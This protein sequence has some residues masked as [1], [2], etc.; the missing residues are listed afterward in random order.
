MLYYV[1]GFQPEDIGIHQ[2]VYQSR[3]TIPETSTFQLLLKHTITL[4]RQFHA[5]KISLSQSL[6][7]AKS[8]LHLIKSSNHSSI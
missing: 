5:T 1:K 4:D 3:C 7:K 2:L 8:L 6:A